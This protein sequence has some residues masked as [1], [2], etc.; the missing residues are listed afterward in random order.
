MCPLLPVL[1]PASASAAAATSAT[2][3]I[4]TAVATFTN[5]IA[6]ATTTTPRNT[7]AIS[8]CSAQTTNWSRTHP[9]SRASA[10]DITIADICP[11]P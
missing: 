9:R 8:E 1:L 6:P 3:T 5:A 4:A 10:T 11:Y 7:S 2:I